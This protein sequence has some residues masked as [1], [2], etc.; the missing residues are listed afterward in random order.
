MGDSVKTAPSPPSGD[1]TDR[2]ATVGAPVLEAFPPASDTPAGRFFEW[3]EAGG[4]TIEALLGRVVETLDPLSCFVE[5]NFDHPEIGPAGAVVMT[6]TTIDLEPLRR[7]ALRSMVIPF[8]ELG[9]YVPQWERGET[10]LVSVS[11]MPERLARRYAATPMVWS[12]NV[13]LHIEGTWVGLVGATTDERGFSSEAVSMVEALGRV[14]VR[15]FAAH[16]SWN[17]FRRT[18]EREKPLRVVT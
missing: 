16:D 15:D 4:R 13:P 10:V 14:L 5:V 12:L 17:D 6:T 8:E 1:G 9:P 11:Q 7:R 18:V 3:I 2:L